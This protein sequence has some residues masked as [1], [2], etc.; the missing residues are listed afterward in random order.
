MLSAHASVKAVKMVRFWRR[1]EPKQPVCGPY[2]EH[3]LHINTKDVMQVSRQLGPT[4]NRT[5]LVDYH[6]YSCCRCPESFY[7]DII[8]RH[9]LN[10][11]A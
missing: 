3:C 5:K 11:E 4:C 10:E 8:T 1:R 7:M 2:M 6:R 9:R